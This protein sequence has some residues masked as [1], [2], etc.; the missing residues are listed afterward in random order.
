MRT[1]SCIILHVVAF[2][3]AINDLFSKLAEAQSDG[4]CIFGNVSVS[5]YATSC[6]FLLCFVLV[7]SYCSSLIIL[8]II[9]SC[10]VSILFI[11]VAK[12]KKK[13][14]TSVLSLARIEKNVI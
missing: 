11:C 14:T 13:K 3:Y 6:E 9:C 10:A 12:R 2:M 1:E 7:R 4:D 5:H 8:V